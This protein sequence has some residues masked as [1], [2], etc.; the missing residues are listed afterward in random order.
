MP[1]DPFKGC[2]D[3]RRTRP[4]TLNP[5]M[6]RRQLLLA[7]VG[8]GMSYYAARALGPARILEA[9]AA[10]SP[11]APVLVSVF[12]PG[13]CDLLSALPPLEQMGR[14]R[15]LRRSLPEEQPIALPG[16]S[17]LGMHPSLGQGA[18]GGIAGM[19]GRGQ[20]GFLPG[21]DYANPDLSHF[22]SRHF[23]DTGLITQRAAPGWLGRWLD[24]HGDAENPLQG[25]SLGRLSPVL[26]SASAPVAAVD[27]ANDAKLNFAGTWDR[28][29]NAARDAWMRLA[30]EA[31][32][33]R[34]GPDSVKR[35]AVLAKTVS[36][37]LTPY[38]PGGKGPDPL[39]PAVEYP[40]GDFG[41]R[42]SRLGALLAQ[43]LGIRV[44]TVDAPGDFDTHDNQPE[45]L[46]DALR[47]VSEGL[48]AFQADL[49]ARGIADRVLTFVWSE[50]GRRPESNESQGTDHGAGGIAWV[51]GTR[52]ASGVLSEYPSLDRLDRHENLAVTVD[53]RRVY[54]S[55]LESWLGTDA[56]QIIP[57]AASFGRLA[58]VR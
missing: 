53:F 12:L 5:A 48:S 54:C 56:G 33:G 47:A 24:T 35:A 39:A 10:Q 37:R 51:Q 30:Q 29:A 26:R 20:I 21:I 28:G 31:P 18:N 32:G 25:M 55:L 36:D 43:P 46:A 38:M 49:E 57:Q 45:E 1:R 27:S 11:E 13:G 7:G 8:A 6:S 9:A 22:H 34:P 4:A 58:V 42:L 40:K 23:W 14:L 3:F 17:R 15:D 41:K 44:A 19:F 52:A 16:E 50:F 2:D